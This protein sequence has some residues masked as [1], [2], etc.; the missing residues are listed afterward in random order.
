MSFGKIS[1]KTAK[2]K[3]YP[4][5]PK[6]LGDHLKKRRHELGLRQKD[7]A[8]RLGVNE[9]TVCYWE[10][11]KKTP[12][13]R[14]F[15][16]IIEFLSYDPFPASLTLAEKLIACRRSLCFSRKKLA[17][18]LFLDE[19]TLARWERATSQPSG[20]H[21]KWVKQFLEKSEFGG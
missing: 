6:T 19:G 21:Q 15:P 16:G 13:I 3:L 7:V 17:N 8:E 20:E 5:E 9:Y 14:Y 18:Q 1:L 12:S 11:N 4:T 10:N 2:F